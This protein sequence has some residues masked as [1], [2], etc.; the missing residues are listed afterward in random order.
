MK[1]TNDSLA[2]KI[3]IHAYVLF[4]LG[5]FLYHVFTDQG[6]V[7]WFYDWQAQTLGSVYTGFTI[8]FSLLIYIGVPIAP[9]LL[10][11]YLR[12]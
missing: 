6:A 7:A 5:L 10:I 1:P 11:R 3:F 12:R 8:A 9:L 4:W 2:Y